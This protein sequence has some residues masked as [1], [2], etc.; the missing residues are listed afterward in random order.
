LAASTPPGWAT[1]YRQRAADPNKTAPRAYR[2]LPMARTAA[3][4]FKKG[5]K[6]YL[7]DD[8]KGRTWVMTSYTDKIVAGLT[9]DK[10][11]ALGTLLTMPPD[12]RY[13]AMALD[14]ELVLVAKSG[15][16]ATI[17]DDEENVYELTGP[18]QSN[19]KP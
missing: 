4:G 3:E 13:R 5:S 14:K 10:L 2:Y 1:A 11:D 18:G 19:F 16:A 8:P 12:W 7:L 17:Q 15:S 9:I 6:V